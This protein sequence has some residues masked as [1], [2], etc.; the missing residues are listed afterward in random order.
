MCVIYLRFF[1]LGLCLTVVS[2]LIPVAM[3]CVQQEEVDLFLVVTP[4]PEVM[5]LNVNI[6]KNGNTHFLLCLSQGL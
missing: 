4:S 5:A 6:P 1:S 2:D 3:S